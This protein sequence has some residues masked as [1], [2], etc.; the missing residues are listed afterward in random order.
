MFKYLITGG[1]GF[2]GSHIVKKLISSGTTPIILLRE[3][4]STNRLNKFL[5][6]CQIIRYGKLS[7]SEIFQKHKIDVLIHAACN[8]GRESNSL[9][10]IIND[11]ILFGARLFEE[12][13]KNGVKYF[14]N[15][16]STLKKNLNS[17]S[18]SKYQFKEWLKTNTSALRV[19]NLRFDH[20][21]GYGDDKNKFIYWFLNACIYEKGIIKLTDGSQERDFINVY[22][23]VDALLEFIDNPM[24]IESKFSTYDVGTGKLT[25]MKDFIMM[26]SEIVEKEFEINVMDRLGWGM[27]NLREEDFNFPSM[28]FFW[29]NQLNWSPKHEIS[30]SLRDIV[31]KFK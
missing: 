29:L 15:I 9:S 18:L 21:Y 16:D 4:S 17:Y 25:K 13:Q 6:Q 14:I 30:S 20:L 3:N 8:Y 23:A 27:I 5:N 24:L 31:K 2:L 11:N 19:V 26:L 12:S 28:D 1:N 22:D 7:I 10:D